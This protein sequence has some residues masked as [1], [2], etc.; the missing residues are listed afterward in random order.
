MFAFVLPFLVPVVIGAV[1]YVLYIAKTRVRGV[2]NR[3]YMQEVQDLDYFSQPSLKELLPAKEQKSSPPIN[4]PPLEG[5]PLS[6]YKHD[7]KRGDVV[8]V[9]GQ[10]GY[11]LVQAIDQDKHSAW[12]LPLDSKTLLAKTLPRQ[13]DLNRLMLAANGLKT[14]L[15]SIN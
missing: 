12:C 8:I 1:A 11:Y 9:T 5:Y 10:Y 4:S 13:Y 7:F 3:V 15:G 14:V 6:V 2:L